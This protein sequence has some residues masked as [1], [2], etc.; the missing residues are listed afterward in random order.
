VAKLSV[1]TWIGNAAAQLLGQHG[2]VTARAQAAACS[3]QTVYDHA[4]KV[5]QAVADAHLPGPSRDDLLQEVHRLRDENRQLW[6]WLEHTIDCPPEKHQQF[7][8]TAAAMGLSLQQTRALLAILLPAKLRPSRA[9]LGRW[10][11]QGARRS[12][13]L[14]RLLDAACQRLVVCLCLD[15]IFFHRRPVLM[16]IEPHSLAWVLGERSAD[17]SGPTWAKALAAWPAVTDIAADGGSGIERGLKLTAQRRQHEAAQAETKAVPLRV[18]LDVFH[19][20]QEGQRALRRE[21]SR[22]EEVWEEAAKVE[23]A[24]ERFDRGGTD[25]RRCNQRGPAKAWEKA[26]A[27]LQAA[28]RTEAAWQR[29]TAALAVFRP[30]GR[31][32]ERAWAAAEIQAASGELTGTYWAKAKRMLL[33][34]RAL[35][36]LDRLHEDL[37][38]AE[39][40]PQRRAGLVALWRWRHESRAGAAMPK[41]IQEVVQGVVARQ[42]GEKWEEAYRRVGRVLRRVVRA[43]SAVECVNSVVRMHQARHR[44]LSQELLDLKRLAW[45]CRP[46]VSGKRRKRCPYEHLGLKL[47]TYDLWTLLQMDHD[48]L[49]QLLSTSVFTE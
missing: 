9:K 7:A 42:L 3:R 37:A 12:G 14:L 6:E 20:Q 44:N 2:A 34:A 4:A 22:A 15:E 16:G 11:Q 1:L 25:R 40:C 35:T 29:A 47:P 45:N 38:V 31:L 10:V 41:V 19:I 21:W 28:T 39:P 46:F 49:K 33:D 24:K 32:N 13:R 23:R 26:A 30:D 18:R 5:H 27:A 43:S 48:H 8:V 17:R 36:F